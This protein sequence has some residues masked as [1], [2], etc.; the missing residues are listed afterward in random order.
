MTPRSQR[1]RLQDIL[2][3]TERIHEYTGGNLRP[4]LDERLTRDAVLFNLTVIGEAAKHLSPEMKERAPEVNW[5]AAAGLR[6]V[7]V[8]RYFGTDLEVIG[9]LDAALSAVKVGVE[10]LLRELPED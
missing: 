10:R 8:H 3:A 6:D 9:A 7:L 1:H 2:E 4:A 5:S